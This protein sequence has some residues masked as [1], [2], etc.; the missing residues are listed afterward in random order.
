MLYETGEIPKV[1]DTV[2]DRLGR[3]GTVIKIGRGFEK[4][5]DESLT[6]KWNEGVVEIEGYSARILAL[7]SRRQAQS[8]LDTNA[9]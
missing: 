3:N 9:R 1:G 7:E 2:R 5:S 6:I 8:E 4:I